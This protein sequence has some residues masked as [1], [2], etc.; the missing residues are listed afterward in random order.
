MSKKEEIQ[1]IEDFLSHLKNSPEGEREFNES[2]DCVISSVPKLGIEH[3]R[4]F[5]PD[6]MDGIIIP[7]QEAKRDQIIANSEEIFNERRDENLRVTISFFDHYRLKIASEDT[8]FSKKDVQELSN[9]IAECIIDNLPE[10]GVTH[11]LNLLDGADLPN[12]IWSISI[13]NAGPDIGPMWTRP[14]G[15]ILP[16]LTTEIIQE[17]IQTHDD[18]VPN[19]LKKC[20]EVWYLIVEDY[21]LFERSLEFDESSKCLA[22]QYEANFDKLFLF[23]KSHN[24]IYELNTT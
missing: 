12:N 9:E 13:W 22:N 8:E 10:Q 17:C 4:L 24:Q 2:P 18:K 6:T 14:K 16:Y 11:N 15:G 20:D 23:R 5:Q 19:Y 7:E 3:T 1:E 21:M